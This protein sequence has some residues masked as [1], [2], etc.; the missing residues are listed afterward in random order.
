LKGPGGRGKGVFMRANRRNLGEYATT[1]APNLLSSAYAGNPNGPT[2]AL[3]ALDGPRLLLCS[4]GVERRNFDSAFMKQLAGGDEFVARSPYGGQA[5]FRPIGKLWV[6]TNSLPHIDSTDDAMWRR[7]E[8]VPFE[9]AV[10]KR[11]DNLSDKLEVEAPGILNWALAGA[12]KF[13]EKQRLP[14]CA[15]VKKATSEARKSGDTVQTW[16]VACCKL[17]KD[18]QTQSSA[19]YGSY[20]SLCRKNGQLPLTMQQL[21]GELLKKGIAEKRT[22][23]FNVYVGIVL[24]D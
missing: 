3:M 21:P 23:K 1:V 24:L 17:K 9:T 7:M 12:K 5:I 20:A 22:S 19:A 13:I 2:P 16:L 15:K 6:S 18:G 4:E 11:D 8:I 10:Q 14:T